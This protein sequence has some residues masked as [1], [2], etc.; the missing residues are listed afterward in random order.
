[1]RTPL[2]PGSYT[3]TLT[4]DINEDVEELDEEKNERSVEFTVR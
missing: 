2:L 3:A 4:L 1:L